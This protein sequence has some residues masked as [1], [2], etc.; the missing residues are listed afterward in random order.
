MELYAR[1]ER[2]L[3]DTRAQ[4]LINTGSVIFRAL[5][6]K[7]KGQELGKVLKFYKLLWFF[8]A[9]MIFRTIPEEA[10]HDEDA[11]G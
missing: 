10:E 7:A 8:D 6:E 4:T 1:L 11:E 2:V 5:H 3:K 9:G